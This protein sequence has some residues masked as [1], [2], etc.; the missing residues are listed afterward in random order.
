MRSWPWTAFPPLDESLGRPREPV[1][2]I[3]SERLSTGNPGR[4]IGPAGRVQPRFFGTSGTGSSGSRSAP[5]APSG[6]AGR[7]GATGVTRR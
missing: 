6:T 1:Y 5:N 3:G 7:T 4:R 2:P